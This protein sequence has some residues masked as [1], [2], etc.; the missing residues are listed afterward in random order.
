MT[1]VVYY[2]DDDLIVELEA[3]E[4][5]LVHIEV[6]SDWKLSK[7]RK[8]RAVLRDLREDL[9]R[10]G[11]TEVFSVI[12]LND[13]KLAKF[14]ERVGMYPILKFVNCIIYRQEV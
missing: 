3:N 6:R 13:D 14:Q 12:P 10:L 9:R 2:E 7:H 8:M 4:S 11:I 5:V 1:K